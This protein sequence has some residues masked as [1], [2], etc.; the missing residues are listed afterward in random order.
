MFNKFA[1]FIVK[2]RYLVL[3]CWLIIIP[4]TYLGLPTLSSVTDSSSTSFLPASSPSQKAQSLAAPFQGKDTA[5]TAT[6]VAYR[7]SGPLTADDLLSIKNLENHIKTLPS[8]VS[9]VDQSQS[10]DLQV[11]TIQIGFKNSVYGPAGSIIVSNIRSMFSSY[12]KGSGLDIHLGGELA[13]LTDSDS[14]DNA[15]KNNTQLI[16]VIFIIILLLIVYRSLLAPLINLIPALIALVVSGPVI[17]ESTKI[18]VQ[19]SS[20]T[21]L[22]LIVL[23]LGAGTDYGLFLIFRF[24]EELINGL[25][26]KLAVIEALSRVGKSITFSGL[27]VI[28][29][30]M[31]LLI[32]QFGFYKG[33]GPALSIGVVI[34]LLAAL[35]LLPAILAVFGDYVFWPLKI[36]KMPEQKLGIWGDVA[37]KVIKKPW[38]TIII[39]MIVFTIFILGT[40]GWKIGGFVTGAP[41]SSSDSAQASSIVAKHFPN[42]INNPQVLLFKFDKSLWTNLPTIASVES[43]LSKSSLYKQINGPINLSDPVLSEVQI[44]RLYSLLGPPDKLPFIQPNNVKIPANVYASYRQLDQFISSDG[45]TIQ[46]F[47]VLANGVANTNQ[48]TDEIPLVRNNI[49]MVASSVGAIANGIESQDSSTYDINKLSNTDLLRIIPLVLLVIAALLAILLRSLIAP[50]YLVITVGLTFLASLGFANIVFVHLNPNSSGLNFVLPFLLFV[51]SMALGE[52]YNILVMNRIREEA[53][54]YPTLSQAITKAIGVTGTTVTSAGLILAGTFIVLAIVGGSSQVEQIGFS[55]AFGIALD[56]FFVRTLLV[57]SIAVLL[58]R[59]NWWPSA[60]SRK[61]Q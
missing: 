36:K 26:K 18:G 3:I 52:D 54:K 33:L 12:S 61:K 41:P 27:T 17:A 56:T 34:T 20:V 50:I 42:S 57:P 19:V 49:A 6:L 16:T 15:N 59:F 58:G 37:K 8:V 43:S 22:L 28:A 30:L 60:L 51:F 29:A 5:T 7:S 10:N 9:I 31:C 39:A 11:R 38:A 55:I 2:Y 46:L 13:T 45:H 44:S 21:Q 25:E 14:V 24:K 23:I 32:A 53:T 40:I 1:H 48:A 35:T 47:V 4:V